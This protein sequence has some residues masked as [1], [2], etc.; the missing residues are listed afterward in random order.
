M[1]KGLK[2]EGLYTEGEGGVSGIERSEEGCVLCMQMVK[3]GC[4]LVIGDVQGSVMCV[5]KVK[6]G[7]QV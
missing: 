1:Y 2:E 6:E 7:Y 5:Q 3:E 4:D